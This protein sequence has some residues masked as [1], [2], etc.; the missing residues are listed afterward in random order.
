[1]M[2]NP[3]HIKTIIHH[4]QGNITNLEA[5]YLYGS[6]T[7]DQFTEM[8]DV[9]LAYLSVDTIS[10]LTRWNISAELASLL[11]RDVDLVDLLYADT[12]HQMQIIYHGK[13]IF[14]KSEVGSEAL[15]DKIFRQYL[16]LNED[17]K[18]ILESIE[19][20]GTVYG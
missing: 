17:R 5:I 3:D 12:V 19:K 6:A 8:S 11:T 13:R 14:C 7:S 20:E 1:M 18:E 4:L 16:T 9:D 10:Q 15:E 2:L